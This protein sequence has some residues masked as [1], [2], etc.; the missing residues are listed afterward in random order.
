MTSSSSPVPTTT[1][2][3]GPGNLPLWTLVKNNSTDVYSAYYSN[4]S[5]WKSSSQYSQGGDIGFVQQPLGGAAYST[6]CPLW[7]H[8]AEF[9]AAFSVGYMTISSDSHTKG[10]SGWEFCYLCETYQASFFFKSSQELLKGSQC[11]GTA[12]AATD[13]QRA[14]STL[15]RSLTGQ[16]FWD[17][18]GKTPEFLFWLNKCHAAGR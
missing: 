18:V 8:L 2:G 13:T 5:E 9:C 11:L 17:I 14:P 1:W 6:F 16:S 3:G 12:K 15:W 7:G 4:S 10:G